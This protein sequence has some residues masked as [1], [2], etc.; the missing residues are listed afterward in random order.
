VFRRK[1]RITP[2]HSVIT[3]FGRSWAPHKLSATKVFLLILVSVLS[4][5]TFAQKKY[6]SAEAR[7]HIGE[8]ATVCGTVASEHLA[9][10]SKG[11]PT[12]VN[13]DKPYPDQVFTIVIWGS[14]RAAFGKLPTKLCVTGKIDLYRGVPEIVARKCAI[15]SPH[16]SW[17]TG[18][19]SNRFRT[20]LDTPR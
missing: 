7:D 1:H 13:L 10:R 3:F 11:E 17:I 2:S 8:T 14:D 20:A 19:M 16:I 5:P 12:F 6:S 15:L 18:Q 9:A 4:L